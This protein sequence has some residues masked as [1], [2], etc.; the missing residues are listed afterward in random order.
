MAEEQEGSRGPTRMLVPI[1]VWRCED[2]KA[3]IRE[4]VRAHVQDVEL[5]KRLEHALGDQV[6]YGDGGGGNVGVA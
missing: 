2:L 6:A 5:A 1:N 3:L 4:N